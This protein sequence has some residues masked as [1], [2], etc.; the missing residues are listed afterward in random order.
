MRGST[1]GGVMERGKVLFSRPRLSVSLEGKE[2]EGAAEKKRLGSQK[3][4]RTPTHN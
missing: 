4:S 1:E 2:K 3:G